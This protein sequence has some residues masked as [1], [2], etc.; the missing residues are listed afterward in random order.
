MKIDSKSDINGVHL[1]SASN[2][3]LVG[4]GGFIRTSIDGGATSLGTFATGENFGDGW[5]A[6]HW[7]VG[8]GIMANL[9]D[10]AIHTLAALDLRRHGLREAD[11]R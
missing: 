3:L 5:Q 10:D 6:G 8:Q 2:V 4:G 11:S 1:K 7:Q 9:P